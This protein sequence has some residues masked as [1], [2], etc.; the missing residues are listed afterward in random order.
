MSQFD[1]MKRRSIGN[2]VS[3]FQQTPVVLLRILPFFQF[4]FLNKLHILIT[5]GFYKIEIKVVF[6]E[7]SP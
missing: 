4:C 1:C 5:A 3:L 2:Y 7:A 6:Q